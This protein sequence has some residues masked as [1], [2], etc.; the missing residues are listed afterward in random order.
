MTQVR[1][2]MP[3]LVRLIVGVIAAFAV[4][5]A[6]AQSSLTATCTFSKAFKL[7]QEE[8]K[9]FPASR[10]SQSMRIEKNETTQATLALDGALRATNSRRWSAISRR[11]FET[12]ES[13]FVGDFGEILTLEHQLGANRTA[14]RGTFRASLVVPGVAST[15]AQV[16]Q[17]TLE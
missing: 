15:L 11:A 3:M 2:L 8:N 14:L 16:G 9:P 12:W 13:R 4:L 6:A 1:S 17:C 5:G 7:D 10:I